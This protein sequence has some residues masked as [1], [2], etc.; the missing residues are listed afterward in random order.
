MEVLAQQVVIQ[1][2][3]HPLVVK[4]MQVGQHQIIFVVAEAVAV[5][6]L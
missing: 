1:V 2:D 5:Q 3:Q 4:A 6:G